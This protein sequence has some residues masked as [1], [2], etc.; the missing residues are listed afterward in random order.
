ME[1]LRKKDQKVLLHHHD[2]LVKS[3]GRARAAGQLFNASFLL[4]F[5][6]QPKSLLEF[7]VICSLLIRGNPLRKIVP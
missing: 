4:Q 6:E 7:L 1:S 2:A 3:N 5:F